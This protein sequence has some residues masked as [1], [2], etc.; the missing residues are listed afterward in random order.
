MNIEDD[1]RRALRRQPAPPDFA[2]RVTARATGR[3]AVQPG[4]VA[5]GRGE[6]TRWLAAAAAVVLLATG[7]A[8]YYERQEAIAEAERVRQDIQVALRIT[9]EKLSLAQQRIEEST[10]DT[11][12]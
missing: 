4:R 10:H 12:R 11:R 2:D 5:P 6:M 7:A 3:S 8:R 1:L 9:S